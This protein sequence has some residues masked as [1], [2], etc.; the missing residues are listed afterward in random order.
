MP[1]IDSTDLDLVTWAEGVLP[2]MP[3]ALDPPGAQDVGTPGVGLYLL[4]LRQHPPMRSS[5]PEPLRLWA[6]YLVHAWAPL[7]AQA[8]E[9]LFELAFS[10]L[11]REDLDVDLE[12]PAP[13]VWFA[14][15]VAPRPCFRVGVPVRRARVTPPVKPVLHPLMARPETFGAVRG[16]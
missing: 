10:A 4:E 14:L 13:D 2:G 12:P 11:E 9:M 1:M 5:R 7:P 3:V 15:G 6:R 16:W 8:H